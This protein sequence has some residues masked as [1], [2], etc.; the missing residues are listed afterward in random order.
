MIDSLRRWFD[1]HHSAGV[2]AGDPRHID[3]LRLLPF[4][5]VHLAC[6]AVPLVGVSPTAIALAVTLYLVRMFGITAGYHRH[7]SHRAFSAPR[8]VSFLLAVLGGSA[9]Q[10][11]VLWWAAHHRHHH[12]HSDDAGDLHSP[13]QHGFWW[14]HLGWF[15]ADGAYRTRLELVPD[16]AARPELMW[17]DRFDAVVPALLAGACLALGWW[18][19]LHGWDTSGPQLLVWFCISTVVLAHATFSVNSVMHVWGTR[20]FPTHDDSRNNALIALL[21]LGEGWHN[22]H[23]HN[24]GSVRQGFRWWQIDLTWYA[25]LVLSWL[26]LVH[27]LRPLPAGLR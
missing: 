23:H 8:W 4:V 7:F 24:Q 17:L 13:R 18:L 11:G 14:S 21:V 12:R 9:G 5:G 15:L 6:L 25:L 3:L 19:G 16:L 10:R 20:P 1:S 2:D 27:R 26:G 22:N